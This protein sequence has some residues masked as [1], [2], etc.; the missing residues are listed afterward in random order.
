MADD[1]DPPQLGP[2]GGRRTK[3]AQGSNPEIRRLKPGTGREYLLARL[4]RDGHRELLAAIAA[5]TLTPHAAAIAVGYIRARPLS[6]TAPPGAANRRQRTDFEIDRAYHNFI[7]PK[8]LI[9]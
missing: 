7:D 4:Q 6:E 3:A 5:G 1:R 8:A 9:G 2:H